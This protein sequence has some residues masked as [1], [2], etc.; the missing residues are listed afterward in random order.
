LSTAAVR[1]NVAAPRFRSDLEVIVQDRAGVAPRYLVRDPVTERVFS[2]DEE[3]WR[4][5]RELDGASSVNDIIARYTEQ[6]GSPIAPAAVDAFVR[7]LATDRLL[8]HGGPRPTFPERLEGSS[9]GFELRLLYADPVFAALERW[10]AW[11][12]APWG[13]VATAATLALGVVVL[14]TSWAAYSEEVSLASRFWAVLPFLIYLVV[15]YPTRVVAQCVALKRYGCQILDLHLWFVYYVVPLVDVDMTDAVFLREKPK[16]QRT[17]LAGVIAQALVWALAIIAWRLSTPGTSAHAIFLAASEGMFAGLILVSLNPFIETDGYALLG[18]WLE[19][20]RLRT[21]ALRACGDWLYVR[22]YREVLTPRNRRWL[23]AYGLMCTAYFVG[24]RTL[25]VWGVGS[26]LAWDGAGATATAGLGVLLFEQPIGSYFNDMRPLVWLRRRLGEWPRG[27]R[28]LALALLLLLIALIPYPYEIGGPM[29]LLPMS[30]R[31]ITAEVEGL[32]SAVFV[33]EGQHVAAGEPIAE[34]SRWEYEV[35]LEATRK[36]LISKAA[37]LELLQ[38]GAKPEL[39]E[40]A[41]FEVQKAEEQVRTAAQQVEAL[42]VRLRYSQ[43]HADRFRQLYA[44]DA[45]SRQDLD[46]ALRERD[47]AKESLDVARS[48]LSVNEKTL[49]V[50]RA[51]LK[52][53]TSPPREEQVRALQAETD[54]LRIVIAGLETQLRLTVLRS[55]VAGRI[56]TPRVQQSV[57]HYVRKGEVFAVVEESSTIQAEVQVPEE[58]VA[59]LA[60]DARVKVVTWTYPNRSFMGRVLFVAPVAA[61]S[62]PSIGWKVVRVLTEIPNDE[63]LLKP[64]MTGYAKIKAPW[65]PV[66]KVLLRPPIRW[67]LV[68]LWYWL[69]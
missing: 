14:V 61:T 54:R 53:L 68:Q 32:V 44:D 67:T 36:D 39:I 33:S 46:N 18:F 43:T 9:P 47:M 15:G 7:Q 49:D 57:G 24:I 65:Q 29:T 50:A 6:Y 41:G 16:R 42:E 21:R 64:S 5:C 48:Q 38:A 2:L 59:T 27:L 58:D 19:A 17:V 63:G 11:L 35:Q 30:S 8:E 31:E 4:L 3:T 23:V 55:T 66:W 52:T 40:R 13:L 37:E 22:P 20:A 28:R 51:E 69:P 10:T 1:D 45:I 25:L 26:N 62:T 34:L 60:P 12:A 56:S